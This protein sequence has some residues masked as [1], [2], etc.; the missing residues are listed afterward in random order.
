MTL[1]AI[2]AEASSGLPEGEKNATFAE[3][4]AEFDALVSGCAFYELTSRARIAIAGADRIRWLNGM[5]TNNIRDLAAGLG[6]YAFV[7]NPQGHILGDLYAYNRGDSFLL[8]T[9]Q[10]QMPKLL[11]LFRRYIIMDKVEA[12]D[13]AGKLAAVGIAGPKSRDVLS[14]A[15]FNVP[16]M[17]PLQIKSMTWHENEAT[18]A[19]GEHEKYESYE[20]WL[21]PES[22]AK[23]CGALQ[24]SGATP[25]GPSALELYRIAL[26]VPRY[27]VDIRE[28]D[29]PQETGQMR[30]LNFNKGCYIGQEIVERIRSRGNVHRKFSGFMIDGPLPP[31]GTKVQADGKDAG[32]ITSSASLPLAGGERRV[33]L[34]Y[35]R[36]E[37]AAQEKVLL[38]GE[39]KVA[40]TETPF[41]GVW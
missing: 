1:T 12:T 26:G 35:I 2:H 10:S 17:Q 20:V 24:Q 6:V 23:L 22:A 4:R 37:A 13:I 36:R 29:L 25:V 8:E 30:A 14:A 40:V 39:A 28:R 19:R 27:G 16:G 11:E 38:A 32:E 15:G 33:A 34:G 3:V 41:A 31:P 18:L 5:I 7:L 9:E 21:A